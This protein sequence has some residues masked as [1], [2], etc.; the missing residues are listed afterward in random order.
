VRGHQAS[1]IQS[2][3]LASSLLL[4]GSRGPNRSHGEDEE[5][6]GRSDKVVLVSVHDVPGNLIP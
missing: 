5:K 1:A 2:S 4:V 6:S 3:V